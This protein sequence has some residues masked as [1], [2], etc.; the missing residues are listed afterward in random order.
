MVLMVLKWREMHSIN[1]LYNKTIVDLLSFGRHGVLLNNSKH[2]HI[3]LRSALANMTF[4]VQFITLHVHLNNN[5]IMSN[6]NSCPY[7]LIAPVCLFGFF[8]FFFF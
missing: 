5:C 4:T 8:F 3:D 7:Q 2:N 6:E 1:L